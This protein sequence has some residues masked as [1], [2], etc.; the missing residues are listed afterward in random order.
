MIS[1]PRKTP[2]FPNQLLV[3]MPK[4]ADFAVMAAVGAVATLYVNGMDH[5]TNAK[6]KKEEK[7]NEEDGT[8][9]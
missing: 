4:V 8:L 5:A 1:L 2:I 7:K 3:R 9:L 6:V